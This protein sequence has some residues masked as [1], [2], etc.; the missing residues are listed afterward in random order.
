MQIYKMAKQDLMIQLSHYLG[1]EYFSAT[2]SLQKNF[3]EIFDHLCLI[4]NI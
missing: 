1:G 4:S 3:F 2:S